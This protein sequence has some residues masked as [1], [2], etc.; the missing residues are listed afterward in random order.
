M[1]DNLTF[2]LYQKQDIAGILRLWEDESGW[3]GVTE[4]QFDD[5]HINTPCGD[6]L[7]VVA[8]DGENRI[9]G[10]EVFTPSKICIDGKEKKGLRISA[11]VLAKEFRGRMS[12]AAHPVVGMYRI[13]AETALEKGF[14]LIYSFP[15]IGWLPVV[16]LLFPLIG[17]DMQTVVQSKIEC[18]ALSL[19]TYSG[20]ASGHDKYNVDSVRSFNDEYNALWRSTVKKFPL[21]NAVVRDSNWLKWKL[22]GHLVL[23]VRTAKKLIGYAAVKRETGLITDALARTPEDFEIVISKAV[24]RLH[25]LKDTLPIDEIKLMRTPITSTVIDKL[26]FQK[27]NYKLG[28]WCY[29]PDN[30]ISFENLQPS[31]WHMMP[32]D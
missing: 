1:N 15:S 19:K 31:R 28:F 17:I 22:G 3:G 21:G 24:K 27:I 9:V 23:E 20:E 8:L 16:K 14:N 2:R 25:E 29:S 5:W 10:Q 18:H 6:C 26:G 13:G 11:P 32:N 7:I 4:K 12:S 30:S